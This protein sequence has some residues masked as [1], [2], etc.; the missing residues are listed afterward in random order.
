[1]RASVKECSP[2]SGAIASKP[3]AAMTSLTPPFPGP[4]PEV[5]IEA[6]LQQSYNKRTSESVSSS[7]AWMAADGNLMEGSSRFLMGN[8]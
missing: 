2:T 1:M 6:E 5:E 8:Q 7:T 4:E 3:Q